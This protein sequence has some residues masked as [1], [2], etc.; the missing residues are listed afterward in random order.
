MAGTWSLTETDDIPLTA[1]RAMSQARGLRRSVEVK[2]SPR[3]L[4]SQS[5]GAISVS[6]ILLNSLRRRLKGA[7]RLDSELESSKES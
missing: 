5:Q 2:G 4:L 7:T 1:Q 3:H 6:Q